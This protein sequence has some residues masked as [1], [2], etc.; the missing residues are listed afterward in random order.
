LFASQ[1]RNQLIGKG[2][3]FMTRP[4]T[5][6]IT[7]SPTRVRTPVSPKLDKHLLAYAAAASAAGVSLVAQPAQAKVVYTSANV[8]IG[9]NQGVN[10]DLNNDGI[11]D[12]SLFFDYGLP[13]RHPEG[14]AFY[15]LML[16]P[17][18]TANEIWGVVSA[19]G[20]Q[21]AAALPAGVKV[22]AGAPFQQHYL[23]LWDAFASYTRG[24]TEHCPWATLHRGAF[25]GLKFVVNG[26]NHYGWA[27][28]TMSPD[29]QTTVLNGYAY[30]T[31]PNQPI[32]TGE[33]NG[34]A[35]VALHSL[36][37]LP[38]PQAASLGLLAQ[39]ARGLSVWHREEN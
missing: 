23:P 5:P 39:G 8:T 9:V 38:V 29:G 17:T 34:P 10:L 32:L 26:Q 13:T 19:R 4:G 33:T 35:T 6:N 20:S 2:D 16:Y 1:V 12:F 37:P 30:E 21:C 18:Q 36:T 14:G 15:A 3:K 7:P 24:K 28:V 11:P 31:V 25:L 27:H 22:G